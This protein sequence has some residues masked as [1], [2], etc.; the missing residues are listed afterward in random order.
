MIEI[1][2]VIPAYNEESRLPTTLE[3]IHGFLSGTGRQ[4][5]ILVVDDG[6]VDSTVDYVKSFS[7]ERPQVRI[8]SYKPNRGKGHAVRTGVLAAAGELVLFDDADGSSPIE[9][10]PKLEAAIA[11]GADIAIGSRAKPDEQRV[12]NALAYRKYVG[13][14]FNMIVQ[15][16]LLPGIFDTQ[17]GFKL[18]K[19][20]VCQDIFSVACQDG[21]AFDVEILYIARRRG[22]KVEEVPINWSNVDGSK[23]NVLTDSPMM[24]L[25]VCKVAVGAWSGKYRRLEKQSSQAAPG[26]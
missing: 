2:V 22:Y 5:E 16:L 23:V 14:T 13:N 17:C 21:F 11:T 7:Q 26:K 1:S 6:S 8:I 19:R 20:E 12:V 24:L 25:D 4:F 18:F 10:L 9:E 15:S 3:S